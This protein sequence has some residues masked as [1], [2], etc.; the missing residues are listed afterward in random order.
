M[1]A[2]EGLPEG[3]KAER[4]G[5]AIGKDLIVDRE[6]VRKA[7][8]GEAG[9]IVSILPGYS[10]RFDIRTNRNYISK[11]ID[12]PYEVLV[13]FRVTDNKDERYLNEIKRHSAF[14]SAAT[15]E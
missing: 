12:S 8:D 13:R 4:Y 9:L 14:V 1:E 6:S 7:Y 3:V 5:L 10:L 11:E 15:V 2:I